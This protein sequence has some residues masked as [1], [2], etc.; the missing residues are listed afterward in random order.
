MIGLLH[1]HFTFGPFQILLHCLA[2][3]LQLLVCE[4]VKGVRTLCADDNL[5]LILLFNDGLG[6]RHKL[7]LKDTEETQIVKKFMQ[8]A[9]GK[10]KIL[11]YT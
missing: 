8:V 2:I 6:R 1:L 3:F 4:F 10:I 7:P 11:K 9:R 5:G